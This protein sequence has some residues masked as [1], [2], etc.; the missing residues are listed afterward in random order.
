MIVRVRYLLMQPNTLLIN[1]VIVLIALAAICTIGLCSICI[2]GA[3]FGLG[4]HIWNLGAT[5]DYPLFLYNTQ[6]ITKSL[7]GGC[8]IYATAITLT[9]CSIIASYL[10]IFPNQHIHLLV[11]CTG[12]L[13]AVMWCISMV[14]TIMQCQPI[15][16]AWVCDSF[17]M[18]NISKQF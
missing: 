10:R 5:N 4:I 16:S 14:V 8:L 1:L 11:Y 13:I 7:F 15:E 3:H 12:S 2:A 18:Q 6:L 9:K 17:Y